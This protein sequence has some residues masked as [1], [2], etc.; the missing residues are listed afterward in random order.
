[1]LRKI[2]L[3]RLLSR[4]N[5]LKD[6]IGSFDWGLRGLTDYITCEFDTLISK[7]DLYMLTMNWIK[8]T[9]KMPD[10][11]IQTSIKG[12]M[13]RIEG[14]KSSGITLETTFI[15]VTYDLK[16]T[17]EYKFRDGKM[18]IDPILL[19]IYVPPSQYVVGGWQSFSLTTGSDFYKWDKRNK[20]YVL[21]DK[22]THYPR[23]LRG[24]YNGLK[25]ILISVH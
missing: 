11:V 21:K 22:Y 9:Y 20:E 18:K 19:Y 14:V 17:I 4:Y 5:T 1:M 8:E 13:I 7:E 24:L 6:S 10:K 12:K 15:T 23:D 16:Y 3:T 25:F 2:P